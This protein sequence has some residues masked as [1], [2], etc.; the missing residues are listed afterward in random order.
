MLHLGA[1]AFVCHLHTQRN[2]KMANPRGWYVPARK[3]KDTK[4]ISMKSLQN[5]PCRKCSLLT[6]IALEFKISSREAVARSRMWVMASSSGNSDWDARLTGSSWSSSWSSGSCSSSCLLCVREGVC[7]GGNLFTKLYYN[8][9]NSRRLCSWL[10][11]SS[12][13]LSAN[14]LQLQSVYCTGLLQDRFLW[15]HIRATSYLVARL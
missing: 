12:V 10:E 15:T 5:T 8:L 2:N 7:V 4:G 3:W 14:W 6:A 13:A 11:L 9:A 1:S